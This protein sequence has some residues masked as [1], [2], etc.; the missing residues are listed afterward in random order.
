LTTKI[1]A[2]PQQPLNLKRLPTMLGACVKFD[3]P[4]IHEPTKPTKACSSSHPSSYLNRTA[5]QISS[6]ATRSTICST[7]KNNSPTS[8]DCPLHRRSKRMLQSMGC[9]GWLSKL[10]GSLRA[11]AP[12]LIGKAANVLDDC[13]AVLIAAQPQNSVSEKSPNLLISSMRSG[14]ALTLFI[15]YLPP[16]LVRSY[17]GGPKPYHVHV[18]KQP[19]PAVGAAMLCM[20]RGG[21]QLKYWGTPPISPGAMRKCSFQR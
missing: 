3:T 9:V 4:I 21:L 20:F 1:K 12:S 13:H 16:S 10:R 11:A 7:A 15:G 8:W 6:L 2:P 5:F 17:P 14:G 18:Q 19:L